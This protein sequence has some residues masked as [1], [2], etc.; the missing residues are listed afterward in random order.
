[1]RT[2]Y[3]VAAALILLAGC[4]GDPAP[5]SDPTP[6]TSAEPSPTGSPTEAA[7]QPALDWQPVPGPVDRPVTLNAAREKVTGGAHREAFLTDTHA[8]VV[9]QDPQE[10]R[11][12]RAVLT[13]LATGEE[14]VIDGRSEV[15]TTTGGTWALGPRTLVHA[16]VSDGAYCLATVD[17]ATGEGEVTWCAPERTGFTEARITD[18]GTTLQTFDDAQPACRTVA[19]LDGDAPEPIAGPPA[20]TAWEAVLLDSGPVWTVVRNERNVE[21]VDVYAQGPDG[22]V[23]IGPGTAGTLTECGGAAYVV[24]DPQRDGDPARL[25]R[26]DGTRAVV[27]YESPAGP[28]F[29]DAPRCGGD[30]ITVTAYAEGGDEQV[31]A[32]LDRGAS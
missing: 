17:L 13:D 30:A 19:S 25:V 16:T 18:A 23:E 9:E 3:G 10:T 6:A 12:A 24:R 22:P 31:T 28:A 11:P 20:C 26:W 5:A 2:R 7:E 4:S 15:P 29:L 27:V 21:A 8:L 14:T 32:R 1:M